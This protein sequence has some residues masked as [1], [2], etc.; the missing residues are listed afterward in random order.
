VREE[1]LGKTLRILPAGTA[2]PPEL[3]EAIANI[4]QCRREA[5]TLTFLPGGAEAVLMM[6]SC[7]RPAP[8]PTPASKP[9]SPKAE[10]LVPAAGFGQC[11]SPSPGRFVLAGG[12]WIG[13]DKLPK[14]TVDATARNRSAAGFQS[15]AIEIRK[16]ERR[17]VFVGG[18][19]V[20]D[21]F[22]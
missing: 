21:A 9:G 1:A 11:P 19:P 8:A 16:V 2:L 22:E 5:C 17:Q 13:D 4:W 7:F 20:G 10:V 3:R 14:P 6:D 12:K 15:G 18:E